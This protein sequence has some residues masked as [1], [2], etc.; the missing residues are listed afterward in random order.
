MHTQ[1]RCCMLQEHNSWKM[2]SVIAFTLTQWT[3]KVAFVHPATRRGQTVGR[4][5]SRIRRWWV[6]E[7]EEGCAKACASVEFCCGW[8]TFYALFWRVFSSLNTSGLFYGYFMYW[9]CCVKWFYFC[10]WACYFKD[11]TLMTTPWSRLTSSC[12]LFN[13][14]RFC[15]LSSTYSEYFNLFVLWPN[16]L[17][18]AFPQDVVLILTK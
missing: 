8:D 15:S 5:C 12:F 1:L 4:E 16:N 2:H 9:K 11:N 14:V 7:R 3:V 13:T 6:K 18:S 10:T 17:N